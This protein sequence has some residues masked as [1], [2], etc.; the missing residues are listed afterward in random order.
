MNRLLRGMLLT[1]F[2]TVAGCASPPSRFYRLAPLAPQH[3]AVPP[4]SAQIVLAVG[5]VWVSGYLDQPPMADT[6]GPNE[7]VYAEFD[8]WAYRIQ[9]SFAQTLAENLGA[10]LATDQVYVSPFI[11]AKPVDYQVFVSITRLDGSYSEP[12][13]LEARWL[14]RDGA[15]QDIGAMH[16]AAIS[17]DA[18]EANHREI[19]A[20]QS[21]ALLRLSEEI[22]AVIE[23]AAHPASHSH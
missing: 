5:P 11:A 3:A 2:I 8:R 23:T 18:N 12:C 4:A 20:A 21:R 14:V 19:A 13:R 22:A 16:H 1:G 15:G 17:E 9:D 6:I 7:I 10:L